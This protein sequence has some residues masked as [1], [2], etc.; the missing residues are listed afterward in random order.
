MANFAFLCLVCFFFTEGRPSTDAP[1]NER[2]EDACMDSVIEQSAMDTCPSSPRHIIVCTRIRIA[3]GG[4]HE[5]LY[6][7]YLVVSV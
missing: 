5:M 4:L 1:L 2:E 7:Q 3:C 6:T